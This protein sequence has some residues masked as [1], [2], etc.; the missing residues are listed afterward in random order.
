MFS[1]VPGKICQEWSTTTV[2]FMDDQID[3][4]KFGNGGGSKGKMT[5]FQDSNRRFE[6]WNPIPF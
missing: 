6:L 2:D 5:E 1:K 4:L 3:E